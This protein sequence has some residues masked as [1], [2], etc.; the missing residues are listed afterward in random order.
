MKKNV[1]HLIAGIIF[2]LLAVLDSYLIH[3]FGAV[4]PA[5]VFGLLIF[6]DIVFG[7]FALFFFSGAIWELDV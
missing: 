4:A 1:M 7:F 3:R 2:L 6:A 5:F